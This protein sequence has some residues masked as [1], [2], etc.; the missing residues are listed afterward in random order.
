MKSI[1]E[2]SLK[3]EL[4]FFEDTFTDMQ[5]KQLNDYI[6]EYYNDKNKLSNVSTH[7]STQHLFED[8]QKKLCIQLIPLHIKAVI[9]V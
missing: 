1:I 6:H 9:A 5:L 2:I 8:I 3:G 4:Y 7:G